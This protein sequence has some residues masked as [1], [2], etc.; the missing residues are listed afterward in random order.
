M[1]K[2]KHDPPFSTLYR[3]TGFIMAAV[4]DVA[5]EACLDY[6]KSEN[7]PLVPLNTAENFR[8]IMSDNILR[9]SFPA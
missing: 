9:G 3:E 6:A 8:S 1:Q 2:W 5:Y 4:G 7:A